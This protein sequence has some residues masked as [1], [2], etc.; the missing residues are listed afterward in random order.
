[1]DFLLSV[2]LPHI[3]IIT[4]IAP[5][6][7][8]QFGSLERYRDEKMKMSK[9]PDTI[10]IAHDSLREF[11]RQREAQFYGEQ[12]SSLARVVQTLQRVD[13]LAMDIIHG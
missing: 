10:V 6:H 7:L 12:D 11:M 5:N 8:E 4:R 1:M 2:A 3:A 9:D 13:S